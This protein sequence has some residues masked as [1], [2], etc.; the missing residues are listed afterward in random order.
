MNKTAKR[1]SLL[2]A[3][4]DEIAVMSPE[5]EVLHVALQL[6]VLCASSNGDTSMYGG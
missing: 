3:N 6:V 1:G 5:P 4:G 2:E